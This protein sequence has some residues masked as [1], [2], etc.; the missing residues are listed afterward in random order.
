MTLGLGAGVDKTHIVQSEGR[1]GSSVASG[2]SLVSA[3]GV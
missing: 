1:M 3:G 2:A